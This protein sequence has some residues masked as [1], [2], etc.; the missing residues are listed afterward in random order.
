VLARGQAPDPSNCKTANCS[1]HAYQIIAFPLPA[2]FV[3]LLLLF[4]DGEQ[5]RG[6]KNQPGARH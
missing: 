6:E 5:I 2:R 4:Q 1:L 3:R